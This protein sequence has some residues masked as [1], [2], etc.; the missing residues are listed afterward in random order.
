M[1]QVKI[2]TFRQGPTVDTADGGL[3][4]YYRSKCKH[5]IIIGKKKNIEVIKKSLTDKI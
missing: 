2:F 3:S 4:P 1:F 5:N